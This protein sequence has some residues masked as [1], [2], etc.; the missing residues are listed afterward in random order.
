MEPPPLEKDVSNTPESVDDNVEQQLLNSILNSLQSPVLPANFKITVDDLNALEKA[1]KIV[2]IK[3]RGEALQFK[4]ADEKEQTHYLYFMEMDRSDITKLIPKRLNRM[5]SKIVSE[6]GQSA[7]TSFRHGWTFFPQYY[8]VLIPKV[9]TGGRKS[10]KS[11]K[12]RKHRKSRRSR[13]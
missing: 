13:R 10:R 2:P 3:D 4:N 7:D 9:A 6:I 5:S 1:V 8:K 12:S 11:R